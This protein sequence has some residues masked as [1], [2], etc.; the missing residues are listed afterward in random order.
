M[1]KKKGLWAN[2]HA[3]RKRG[4]APAKKGDKNYP[5]TLDIDEG[6]MKTARKN[7]G[8]DKC[9]DG[10]TAKGTKKKDGKTVPNCVKE[11]KSFGQFCVEAE[12]IAEK[13]GDGY[14]GPRSLKI[15]N[16]LASDATRAK[17]DANAKALAKKR[18]QS[19]GQTTGNIVDRIQQRKEMIDA[20]GEESVEIEDADGQVFAEIINLIGPGE[21]TGW[22]QQVAEAAWTKKAG[23]SEAGGLNEKGRKSY[24][25][26]NPGSDLKAPSKK[27]GN[28]RRDSFCAR[29]GGMKKK[30]TSAKTA[31]DPDSRINKSLR[32]WNC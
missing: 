21:M 4:E 8:A 18:L 19:G 28:K 22:R 31:N 15:K 30:L 17:T 12:E 10:Y 11:M 27:V 3:K 23:K 5:E 32:A 1:A 7:V 14:I 20:I 24:E 9:W 16:P 29:M 6:S 2:I 26:E 13:A 25:R